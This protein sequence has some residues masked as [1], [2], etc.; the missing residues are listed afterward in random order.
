MTLSEQSLDFLTENLLQ[1][2]RPW[3]QQNKARYKILVEEPLLALSMTLSKTALEI[4]P[5]I[6]VAP[7]K[8]L[9][10]IWRDM[11][12]AKDPYIFRD[13]MWLIF[14]RGKGMEYPAFFFE[15][16]PRGFRY[17][18]GYY[19][20]PG[21]VMETIRTWVLRDDQRYLAAQNAL[22]ALPD[23]H[24]VGKEYKR[25]RYPQ[26]SKEKQLWLERKSL[27]VIH[28][29]TDCALL[30]SSDLSSTLAKT[31]LALKPMYELFLAAHLEH[32]QQK[33]EA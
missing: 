15:L 32:M 24:L 3:F 25:P 23:F 29:E 22:D 6:T 21:G 27:A 28:E 26:Q 4:D 19:S 2:S 14:R 13:V 17:G 11:R 10:R 18:V 7:R 12:Y 5:L 8:T 31:F 1:N 9:S 20:A 33:V 30:F 16:S